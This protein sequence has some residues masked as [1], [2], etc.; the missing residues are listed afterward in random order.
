MEMV[1]NKREKRRYV[2][3]LL[4]MA[5]MLALV[6]LTVS[7]ATVNATLDIAGISAVR[8]ANWS[9]GFDCKGN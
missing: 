3:E 8:V 5:F 7:Y 6:G 1:K 9:I 2:R 4:I